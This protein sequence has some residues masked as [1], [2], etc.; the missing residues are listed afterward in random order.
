M[1]GAMGDELQNLIERYRRSGDSRLFAPLADAYRKQGDTAKAI[2]LLE[3]GLER[4]PGYASGHVIL[5]KCFY[6]TGATERAK[7]EFRRVLEIDADNMVALKYLGDILLAEDRRTDAADCYRRL[8]AIDP[9]NGEAARALKEME[10]SLI[11]KEIDLADAKAARDE[12]PRELATMTLA[13]I[14]AAQGYYNKALA[15]YREVLA[16]EPGNRE[17]K[18]MV[19]KIQSRLDANGG[20][21]GGSLDEPVLSITLD[22]V[23]DDIAANTV[24]RGGSEA[25]VRAE[26]P[27]EMAAAAGVPDAG[28]PASPASPATPREERACAEKEASGAAGAP[29]GETPD[30]APAAEMEQFRTWLKKVRGR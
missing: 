7:A 1:G 9:T 19:A 17:A 20:E 22:D 8:L 21:G 23:G 18:E 12:R 29:A 15:I 11:V 16:R 30:E 26:L 14:Y 4:F 13:G 3:K 25:S 2:E 6:D 27:R 28:Q 24:G 5:G 10:R